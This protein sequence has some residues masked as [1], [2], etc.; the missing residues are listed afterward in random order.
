MSKRFKR[1]RAIS[2]RGL[3]LLFVVLFSSLFH[4]HARAEISNQLEPQY[5]E[6]V[7]A[8]NGGE[9]NRALTLLG[10]IL[11]QSPKTTEA[12]ELKALV[13]KSMQDMTRA[14]ETYKAL[15]ELKRTDKRPLSEIAPYHFEM[16]VARFQTGKFPEAKEHF[17]QS[18]RGDFNR[19]ASYFFLGMI[20]FQNAKWEE[21]ETYFKE[22]PSSTADDLKPAAHFYLGQVY[23][24]LRFTSGSMQH[25]ITAR[26]TSK[27]IL[28]D[29]TSRAEA[30]AMAK[31]IYDSADSTLKPMDKNQFFGNIGLLSGWD[32]N[33]L[34]LPSTVSSTS[35][36]GKRTLKMT[37]LGAVGYM[38]SPLKPFQFV[39]SYRTSYNYNFNRNS[40]SAE[41]F[42]QTL[43]LY[44]NRTPL[45]RLGY[46]LKNEGTLTFQ[47]TVDP[48]TDSSE[49]K[50]LSLNFSIGPYV[51]YE[52]KPKINI[53]GE[54]NIEPQHYYTDDQQTVN[55]K[56]SANQIITKTFIQYDQGEKYFNPLFTV[57]AFF[58]DTDGKDYR[59]KGLSLSLS[60]TIYI[61]DHTRII[62][63]I[64]FTYTTYSE[65][66]TETRRDQNL[67]LGL[68]GVRKLS[69]KLSGV[70]DFRFTRNSSNIVDTYQYNRFVAQLGVSYA[71]F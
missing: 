24:K 37:G 25:L 53:G 28:E 65:R 13:F 34:T 61:K 5:A 7:L 59:A 66:T 42:A 27:K 32:S 9:Y 4:L 2:T 12:L 36:T 14:T 1:R 26:D 15:I 48:T 71:L 38:T 67:V 16:G 58:N 17:Y 70:A 41:Y 39:P 33:I 62:P 20:A 69:K 47:R 43:A 54:I 56:L 3:A 64:D 45:G 29:P 19:G 8:F 55:T 35:A 52:L 60:N 6:A 40:R 30:K 10:E 57:G 63:S 23:T 44:I 22:V 51:R 18:V 21:A 11:R 68:S 49:L 46:G 31:Q 50:I